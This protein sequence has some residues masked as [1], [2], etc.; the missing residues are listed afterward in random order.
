VTLRFEFAADLLVERFAID[1][2]LVHISSFFVDRLARRR[3][4]DALLAPHTNA[5]FRPL[6]GAFAQRCFVV[7]LV[8]MLP[9]LQCLHL[10]DDVEKLRESREIAMRTD[11]RVMGEYGRESNVYV[12]RIKASPER[13]EA[14]RALVVVEQKMQEMSEEDQ[15]PVVEE[16]KIKKKKAKKAKKAKK[17]KKLKKV[18][19]EEE[20][21]PSREF[22]EK[23]VD[24]SEEKL[25][26]IET[27]FDQD[28]FNP[29][30]LTEEP[31]F[32]W[33]GPAFLN[34]DANLNNNGDEGL[35]DKK[36]QPLL[37]IGP[38]QFVDPMPVEEEPQPEPFDDSDKDLWDTTHFLTN[39]ND[40]TETTDYRRFKMEKEMRMNKK[41]GLTLKDKMALKQEN[42]FTSFVEG[43]KQQPVYP[44]SQ[45]LITYGPQSQALVLYEQ[46]QTQAVV[47]F[48]QKANWN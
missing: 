20:S 12:P 32:R 9:A 5:S 23:I 44:G 13:P 47:P 30:N 46:P 26:D 22:F 24:S 11:G 8:V 6:M 40:I 14:S 7:R 35:F 10:L 2:L 21:E 36:P 31:E 45:L 25:P 29:Q 48:A 16:K 15:G 38:P 17:T 3:L 37:A 27:L 19:R 18:V 42:P 28:E 43:P 1:E 41:K 34:L 4:D 33:A 39:L